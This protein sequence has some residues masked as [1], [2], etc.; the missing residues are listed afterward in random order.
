M[1][2]AVHKP[3]HKIAPFG[4]NYSGKEAHVKELE[5]TDVPPPSPQ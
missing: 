5:K 1:K 3:V 2:G 4:I